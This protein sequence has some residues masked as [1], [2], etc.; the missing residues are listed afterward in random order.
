[1]EN[2]PD[3]ARLSQGRNNGDGSWSLTRDDLIDLCYQPADNSTGAETLTVRIIDLGS[4]GGETLAIH[5]VAV[6][7]RAPANDTAP[8]RVA[9]TPARSERKGRNTPPAPR[10]AEAEPAVVDPPAPAPA[11]VPNDPLVA[12]A[13]PAAPEPVA[14]I[15]PAPEPDRRSADAAAQQDM[16][17]AAARIAALEA[18][19]SAAKSLVDALRAAPPA[20]DVEA[21]RAAVEARMETRR[22]GDRII[23]LEAELAAVKSLVDGAHAKAQ[24]HQATIAALEEGHAALEREFGNRIAAAEAEACSRLE[25]ERSTWHREAEVALATARAMWQADEAGRFSRAE[26][27]WRDATQAER[28]AATR[29]RAT[30]LA[31]AKADT[32]ELERLR[33]ALAA[34]EAELAAVDEAELARLQEALVAANAVIAKRDSE[35][36]TARLSLKEVRDRWTADMNKAVAEA[37]EAWRVDEEARTAIRDAEREKEER[38]TRAAGP[39][40]DSPTLPRR[41]LPF[42]AIAA[43]AAALFAGVLIGPRLFSYAEPSPAADT[44]DASDAPAAPVPVDPNPQMIVARDAN[45][46]A[47][48]AAKATLVARLRAGIKVSVLEHNGK[49]LRVQADGVDAKDAQSGWVYATLLKPAADDTSL[50]KQSHPSK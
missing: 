49:W 30:E 38:F 16:L 40:N 47:Q 37:Q 28:D 34:A 48:P 41:R 21:E 19:L 50:P 5:D 18:E 32:A 3:R 44:D 17:R 24:A 31:R 9:P 22:A 29:V 43:V 23:A 10:P 39:E 33:A 14:V 27:Q 25:G 6:A 20:R 8:G 2:V 13:V 7:S 26:S 4:G 45:L 11:V 42:G 35:L 1:V 36:V 12:A 15:P 46:R